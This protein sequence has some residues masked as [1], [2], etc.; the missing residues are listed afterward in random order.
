MVEISHAPMRTWTDV[1]FTIYKHDERALPV[2][3]TGE[4]NIKIIFFEANMLSTKKYDHS[5]ESV[6]KNTSFELIIFF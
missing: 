2:E 3:K 6:N 4:E 1:V 5:L